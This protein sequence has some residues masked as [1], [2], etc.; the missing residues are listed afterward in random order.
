MGEG[1][2][3]RKGGWEGRVWLLNEAPFVFPLLLRFLRRWIERMM[4][5]EEKEDL[6]SYKRRLAPLALFLRAAF[7]RIIPAVDIICNIVL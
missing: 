6:K 3:E 7:C 5:E 2:R 1:E 4:W